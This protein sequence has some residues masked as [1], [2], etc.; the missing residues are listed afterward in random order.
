M[1]EGKRAGGK[2]FFG[3][4][5]R[6]KVSRAGLASGR[7]DHRGQAFTNQCLTHI[8]AARARGER[9]RGNGREDAGA[10][11]AS[12]GRASEREREMLK[13]KAQAG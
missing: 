11:K 13:E 8:P 6:V 2:H 9:V 4:E 1:E 12:T 10:E 7:L 3:Q 5:E